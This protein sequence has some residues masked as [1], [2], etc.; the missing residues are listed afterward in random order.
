MAKKAKP[1]NTGKA[2]RVMLLVDRTGSM[3]SHW[4]ETIEAINNYCKTM[5]ESE[6]LDVAIG[7]TVFDRPIEKPEIAVV[8]DFTKAAAW[9]KIKTS[10]FPPRGMTPLYD[11]IG[12]ALTDM[13]ARSFPKKCRCVFVVMTDGYE[14][15]SREWSPEQ[16]RKLVE[17]TKQDKDWE[18]VFLGA[19]VDAFAASDRLGINRG[20]TVTL[21]KSNVG[22]AMHATAMHTQAFAAS[23][24]SMTYSA[25]ERAAFVSK[26]DETKKPRR[27]KSV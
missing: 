26:P 14:N 21:D 17:K 20:S 2:C 9:K 19:D 24:E 4:D 15:A 8:R 7:L 22:L 16:I 6:S 12:V 27:R 25:A 18:V 11:A 13:R 10:D 5:F 3:K 23:G 1:S